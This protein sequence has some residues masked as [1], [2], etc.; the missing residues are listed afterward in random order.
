MTLQQKPKESDTGLTV[1]TYWNIHIPKDLVP[2]LIGVGIALLTGSSFL[3]SSDFSGPDQGDPF[4]PME[5]K[6]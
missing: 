2:W 3:L 5:A 1:E 6:E 4:T